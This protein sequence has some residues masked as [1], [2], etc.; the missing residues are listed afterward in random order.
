MR[1]QSPSQERRQ[2]RSYIVTT[3]DS[4]VDSRKYPSKLSSPRNQ[5]K[6]NPLPT[7]RTVLATDRNHA[8][9]D[10]PSSSVGNVAQE[11][12]ASKE[13]GKVIHLPRRNSSLPTKSPHRSFHHLWRDVQEEQGDGGVWSSPGRS[14]RRS[15]VRCSEDIGGR[16]ERSAEMDGR[17]GVR[18]AGAAVLFARRGSKIAFYLHFHYFRSSR[19]FLQSS[20]LSD[21]ERAIRRHPRENGRLEIKMQTASFLHD[22]P[23][24]R[25]NERITAAIL[26][27]S[28]VLLRTL[29]RRAV[30]TMTAPFPIL[31]TVSQV[32]E[33]RQTQL[34]LGHSVGFVPTMGALHSG[35]LSLG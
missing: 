4:P 33:W 3:L 16:V 32:R 12:T 20:Q 35:H 18:E 9:I 26:S 31:T 21:V 25:F 2:T 29:S 10:Y 23:S 24:H 6:Y 7:P 15:A 28:T 1:N 5:K 34:A 14:A 17:R 30:S 13:V 22:A 8:A 11:S 19:V 27:R